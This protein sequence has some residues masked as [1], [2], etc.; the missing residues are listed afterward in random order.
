M[1]CSASRTARSAACRLDRDDLRLRALGP[2]VRDLVCHVRT[3]AV[4]AYEEMLNVFGVVVVGSAMAVGSSK[5]MSWANDSGLPLCG[6]ALAR[7]SASVCAAR[8]LASWKFCEPGL[9]TLWHSSMTTASQRWSRRK[10]R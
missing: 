7:I 8:T 6:V 3:A 4:P 1:C 10:R 5:L 9:T 2:H